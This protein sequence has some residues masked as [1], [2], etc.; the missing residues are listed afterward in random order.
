VLEKCRKLAN[1]HAERA[2]QGGLRALKV[3]QLR[4]RQ[5]AR[6]REAE[7]SE[8]TLCKLMDTCVAHLKAQGRRSH[9]DAQQIFKHVVE[10]WP[11]IADAPAVDLTPY[12]VLDT[13]RRLIE[14]GKGAPPTGCARTCGR[15][16]S[17]CSTSRW[18]RR[19][20]WRSRFLAVQVNPVAQTRRS[21]QYDRADNRPFS[22]SELRA[23]WN[24]IAGRP[25]REAAAALRLHLTT[26]GQRI[27]QF[28]RSR[29]ADVGEEALTIFDGKGRPAQGP[30]PHQVPLLRPALADLASSKREGEFAI[31]TTAGKSAISG[32]TLAGWA[33]ALVGDAI[34]GFQLKR[35]RSSVETVL[36]A[37]G[38]SRE[39]R[40]HLQSHGLIGVQARHH[41]GHDYLPEKRMAL[42]TL[43]REVCE[44]K[45]TK[46]QADV[47]QP[48]RM[49]L[50]M[51][52]KCYEQRT[53]NAVLG[54]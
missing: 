33:R 54:R 43:A 34:E 19:P 11:R 51:G 28:V 17:A 53:V 18:W 41:D 36:A 40:G 14:A 50:R 21:P 37:R 16:S 48:R 15:G 4:A 23:Y 3:E 9:V 5:V 10:A 24:L 38:A 12:Q 29:W 45:P 32:R 1:V 2:G 44:V 25:G 47:P 30:R 52:P 20:R 35:I 13:L 8:R 39:V 22:T 31:S 26:G 46:T 6:E 49:A 42:E 27:E 7:L